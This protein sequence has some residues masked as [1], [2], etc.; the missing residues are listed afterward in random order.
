ML[1]TPFT[2]SHPTHPP[3]RINTTTIQVSFTLPYDNTQ[4]LFLIGNALTHRT[5]TQP[6]SSGQHTL[7][8]NTTDNTTDVCV[9]SCTVQ[10]VLAIPRQDNT[11]LDNTSL[12]PTPQDFIQPF[13]QAP[14]A[15]PRVPVSVA[16]DLSAPHT[17]LNTLTV[18]GTP[19]DLSVDLQLAV[20][21]YPY[22]HS[23]VYNF[24]PT[25]TP[26]EEVEVSV[27]SSGGGGGDMEGGMVRGGC[28]LCVW[29]CVYPCCHATVYRQ[30]CVHIILLLLT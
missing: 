29:L 14:L 6:L 30:Y 27:F 4:A 7:L 18:E 13:I 10:V 5:H 26:G 22:V 2:P 21:P 19:V 9:G 17:I 25:V 28:V 3:Q 8:L 23:P 16:F 11:T 12:T 1:S 20:M 15:S 24:T